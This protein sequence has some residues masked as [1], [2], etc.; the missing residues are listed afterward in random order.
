MEKLQRLSSI[1][2]Q[3]HNN[4]ILIHTKESNSILIDKPIIE[5]K[6]DLIKLFQ[7]NFTSLKLSDKQSTFP[8][9]SYLNKQQLKINVHVKEKP[10]TI[11][12][13]FEHKQILIN[14]HDIK[15]IK[16]LAFVKKVLKKLTLDL[17][18]EKM[19]LEFIERT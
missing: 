11:S 8:Y 16:Q 18:A 17:S 9:V 14:N 19:S 4:E 13:N 15:S 7:N 1:D 3:F 2:L 5:F 6:N 10:I 12:I